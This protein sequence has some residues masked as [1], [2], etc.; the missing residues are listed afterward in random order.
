MTLANQNG[1]GA[2]G[3]GSSSKVARNTSRFR[4]PDDEGSAKLEVDID[5]DDLVGNICIS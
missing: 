5:I 1:K 3:G 2:I 4:V